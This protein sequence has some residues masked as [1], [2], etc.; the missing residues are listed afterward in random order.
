[1][2]IVEMLTAVS[3]RALRGSVPCAY[4]HE[5]LERRAR[6]GGLESRAQLLGLFGENRLV[7]HVPP[8]LH[9]FLAEVLTIYYLVPAFGIIVLYLFEYYLF[10]TIVTIMTILSVVVS[11]VSARIVYNLDRRCLV[12]CTLFNTAYRTV[13]SIYTTVHSRTYTC[14]FY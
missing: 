12:Y 9:L 14:T 5:A 3:R 4:F 6:L 11:I 8:V 1:M 2:N 13:L 7:V 10:T